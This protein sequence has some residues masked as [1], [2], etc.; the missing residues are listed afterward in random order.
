MVK[1]IYTFANMDDAQEFLHHDD[2]CEHKYSCVSILLPD[3]AC[4]KDKLFLLQ[5]ENKRLREELRIWW[6]NK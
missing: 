2:D 5:Q 1:L 6:G 4:E 3:G